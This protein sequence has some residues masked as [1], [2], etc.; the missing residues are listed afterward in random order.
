[1]KLDH[2]PWIPSS[3]RQ[4]RSLSRAERLILVSKFFTESVSLLVLSIDVVDDSKL[5]FLNSVER[6]VTDLQMFKTSQ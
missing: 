3:Q 6:L 4:F 2:Y 5:Q 1:M